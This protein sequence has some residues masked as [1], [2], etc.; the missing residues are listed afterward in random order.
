MWAQSVIGRIDSGLTGVWAKLPIVDPVNFHSAVN[1]GLIGRY[2]L[3]GDRT[4]GSVGALGKWGVVLRQ[5]PPRRRVTSLQALAAQRTVTGETRAFDYRAQR[6]RGIWAVG[7]DV[8]RHAVS[9][10]MRWHCPTRTA[11]RCWDG[12]PAYSA[13]PWRGKGGMLWRVVGRA[14]PAAGD[15]QWRCWHISRKNDS[16]S[17]ETRS[18]KTAREAGAREC[19]ERTRQFG[20]RSACGKRRQR[21]GPRYVMFASLAIYL[22]DIHRP[23]PVSAPQLEHDLH[24][25][26]AIEH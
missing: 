11:G 4:R 6:M 26:C 19:R 5:E 12:R 13:A 2:L 21:A 7:D 23:P 10:A 14:V 16:K 22:H 18:G 9:D 8:I 17:T 24:L 15:R 1:L 25:W 20:L 3:S